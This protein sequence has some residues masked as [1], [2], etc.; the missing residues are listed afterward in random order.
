MDGVLGYLLQGLKDRQLIDKLNI[1][2]VSDH[3]MGNARGAPI[4]VQ[5]YSNL[6]L[7][8]TNKSVFDFV[9]SVYPKQD[10][11]LTALY[12]SLSKLPNSKV[13][14]KKD[15]PVEYHYTNSNR[16]GKHFPFFD[17]NKKMIHK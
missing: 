6:D 11:Q 14:Y 9:S 5:N 3:G 12:E 13:F 10:S 4:L 7:I 16:I 8:D 17:K 2:I 15:V 1:I